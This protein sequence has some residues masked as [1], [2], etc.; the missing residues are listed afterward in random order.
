VQ[1]ILKVTAEASAN[2]PELANNLQNAVKEQLES[3][4]GLTVSSVKVIIAD[5]VPTVQPQ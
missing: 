3:M 5:V 1:I 4:V 2:M